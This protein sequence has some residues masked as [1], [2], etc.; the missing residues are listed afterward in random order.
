MKLH[1]VNRKPAMSDA[2]HLARLAGVIGPRTDFKIIVHLVRPDD[3]AV[4][5]RGDEGIREPCKDPLRIVVDLRDL[6]MHRAVGAVDLPA[7]HF[8]D[9]LMTQANAQNGHP[10]TEPLDH[11]LGDPGFTGSARAGRN[12]DPFGTKS[13]NLVERSLVVSDHTHI[14]R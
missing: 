10:G 8:P 3:E 7:V 4:I 1:A 13:A 14:E 12:N 2:H 5:P 6:A 9:A 11:V